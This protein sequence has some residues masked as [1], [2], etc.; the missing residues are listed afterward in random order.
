MTRIVVH[1]DQ[2][3]WYSCKFTKGE[4]QIYDSSFSNA[5]YH[6]KCVCRFISPWFN[7]NN[8]L[9]LRMRN[10][11]EIKNILSKILLQISVE[12]FKYR[13]DINKAIFSAIP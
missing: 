4:M 1:C 8:S 9:E 3:K 6:T 10:Q 5:I 11:V 13:H 2:M 7:T 12:N